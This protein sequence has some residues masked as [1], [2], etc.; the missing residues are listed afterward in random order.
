MRCA[1]TGVYHERVAGRTFVEFE[2]AESAEECARA[3]DG[4][5]FDGRR[6]DA[7]YYPVGAFYAGVFDEEGEPLRLLHRVSAR[8]FDLLLPFA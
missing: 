6:V 3:M 7:S 2:A 1:G 5:F 8:H 4:R